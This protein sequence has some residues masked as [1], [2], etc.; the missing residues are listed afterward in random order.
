MLY[1]CAYNFPAVLLTLGSSAW[2][3]LKPIHEKLVRDSRIKVRKT[4]AY[5]LF[6]LAKILGSALTESDLLPVLFYFM[7]DLDEVKEG[8]MV[9]LP[10][11]VAVL[12]PL[13]RESFVDKFAAAWVSGEEN[14]R[15]RA[16]QTEQLGT[17]AALF[18]PE[19]FARHFLKT[20]FDM[21]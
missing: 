18:T 2:S 3:K 8:V 7:K 13:Q 12:E 19:V 1:H 9:S 21:C 16:L 4:L 10:D 20:F 17:M 15:K 6:E 5:S 14:W 11:L